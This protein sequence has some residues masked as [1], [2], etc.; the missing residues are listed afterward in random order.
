MC[1]ALRFEPLLMHEEERIAE[2]SALATAIVRE[3]YDPILGTAQNDYM[4]EKFQSPAAVADQLAHGYRYCFVRENGAAIGFFAFYPRGEALYLS[5]LYLQKTS[6]G[7]GYARRIVA[8]LQ[9]IARAEG[10][11]AIEL[12]VNKYNPSVDVYEALGFQRL[13]SE[14]IDIGSGYF[15]DDYVYGLPV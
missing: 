9:E 15:M 14:K 3:H 7:K 5:K 10:L 1:E 4:L 13:R 2:M 12:N 8:F 11:T 6:R